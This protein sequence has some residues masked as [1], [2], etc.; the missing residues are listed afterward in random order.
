[1]SKRHIG[2]TTHNPS[3]CGGYELK[4]PG[5]ARMYDDLKGAIDILCRQNP[6]EQL[7]FH[8]TFH[9]G[10]DFVWI[11]AIKHAV[12][13]YK[14]VTWEVHLPIQPYKY[15]EYW[16]NEADRH[17]FNE[18]VLHADRIHI[19]YDRFDMKKV[20]HPSV[21]WTATKI[22]MVNACELL[23]VV[24]NKSISAEKDD[25]ITTVQYAEANAVIVKIVPQERYNN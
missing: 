7:V 10:A 18:N 19:Y 25:T 5:Y 20:D 17:Y 15:V 24:L 8:T 16:K 6:N 14:N 22:N 13:T 12:R 4:T 21:L 23:Y 11:E 1:M 3:V 2:F 9:L